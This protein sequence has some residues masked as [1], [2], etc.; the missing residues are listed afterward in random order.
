MLGKVG[1]RKEGSLAMSHE[2]RLDFSFQELIASPKLDAPLIIDGI[3][4]HG[5]FDADGHYRSPRTLWRNPAIRAWQE[6]HAQTSPLSLVEIPADCIPPHL[7]SVEQA[8]LLLKEGI[9]EPMVRTLTEIA[10]LEGF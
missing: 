2:S 1:S 5:G 9:R 6:Q 7:P 8:K 4:C 10:I 3:R